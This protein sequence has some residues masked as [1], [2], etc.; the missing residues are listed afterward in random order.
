[1]PLMEQIKKWKHILPKNNMNIWK[2]KEHTFKAKLKITF[3]HYL[4]NLHYS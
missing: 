3:I 4:P 1:M 2:L